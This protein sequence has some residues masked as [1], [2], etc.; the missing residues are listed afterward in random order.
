MY[1]VIKKMLKAGYSDGL[2]I[3]KFIKPWPAASTNKHPVAMLYLIRRRV[4][5]YQMGFASGQV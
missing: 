4:F 3:V 5:K 1:K 2:E